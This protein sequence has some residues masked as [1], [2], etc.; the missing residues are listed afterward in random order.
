MPKNQSYSLTELLTVM[1][2]SLKGADPEG[3]SRPRLKED[4]R[5]LH[6]AFYE[7]QKR[8][9]KD[10]PPLR[11]L[12]FITAGPFPYSPELT[13]V[14]DSL[15]LSGL[16]WRENPSYKH[17]SFV[18]FDDSEEWLKENRKRVTRDDQKLQASLDAAVRRLNEKLVAA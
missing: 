11:D 16:I 13:E 15:Q 12:H 17:F 6:A 14:L 3:S 18:E 7:L 1:L 10:F 2:Q 5:F 9:A 8:F 4:P